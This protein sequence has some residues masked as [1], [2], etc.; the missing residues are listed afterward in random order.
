MTGV[1]TGRGEP[2][3]V[4]GLGLLH[5]VP[6]LATTFADLL[7]DRA[8]RS[9]LVHVVDP[10]LL[11]TAIATGVDD[12]VTAQVAA[13][14][15]HLADRGASAV[16]VTCSSIGE[17]AEAAAAGAAVPVLRVDAP[18]AERAAA[19]A[20]GPGVT[21]RIVVLATLAATLGPT[22]RLVARAVERRAGRSARPGTPTGT[23]TGTWTGTAPHRDVEVH[24]EGVA[25]AAAARATGDLATH[26]RLVAEA[27]RRW[28]AGADVVVLAQA[29][30][31]AA[32][33]AAG[34]DVP[35]LTSPSGGADALVA[36]A[37]AAGTGDA[38]A[39]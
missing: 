31:A 13:H 26:D 18:M 1:P 21:G 10:W 25:G 4:G 28:A 8:P 33:G 35:V 7:A 37:R 30:M 36:A 27:V 24:S 11:G 2:G 15:G 22:G 23:E 12:D 29:S 34:V 17:A 9:R 38:G 5:T 19:L 32:A 14:V 16:L 3:G 20:T 6:S 39:R